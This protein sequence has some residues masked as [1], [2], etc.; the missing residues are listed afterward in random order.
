MSRSSFAL[1]VSALLVG[2]VVSFDGYRALD[3]NGNSGGAGNQSGSSGR[4]GSDKGGSGAEAGDGNAR[5]GEPAAA[6][7]SAGGDG[8]AGTASG[9]SGGS[10]GSA[11]N[12][13]T[14]GSAG[15]IGAAGSGEI[16]SCP[17]TTLGQG[18]I[19]VPKT[20]GGVYCIDRTEVRNSDYAAFLADQ[21]DTSEQGTECSWNDSFDPETSTDCSSLDYDPVD[22]PTHPVTCIDWCDAKK[23]CEWAGKELCGAIEGGPVDP[24]DFADPAQDAWFSACTE[25]GVSQF[26]YGDTYQ[27]QY[28]NGIDYGSIST[29]ATASLANCVGGYTGL[30]DMS[31]N[32]SEWENA[33]DDTGAADDQCLHRGGDLF[34]A[35]VLG[36]TGRTLSCNSSA[37]GDATPSPATERRDTRHRYIGFRCC[38][39]P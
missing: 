13:G 19:A 23:F 11:G 32:V 17:D 24:L 15:T 22:Q 6:G 10:S 5:G 28:C 14:S 36:G 26:P 37:A 38:Y 29:V 27:S 33:C 9:G 34:D 1:A 2:C 3:E 39:A 16:E 35:D 25:N 31:G 7:E 30:Y 21:P 8:N 20:D 4:G 12:G 18:L